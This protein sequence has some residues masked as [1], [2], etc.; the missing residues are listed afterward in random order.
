MADRIALTVLRLGKEEGTRFLPYDDATG[1]PIKAPVGKITW[2]RGFNLEAI[3]SAPLFDLIEGF[4]LNLIQ[5]QIGTFKWYAIADE[6]RKSVFLDIAYNDGVAGLLA[7]D[8]MLAAAAVED[9]DTAA[10]ECHVRNPELTERYEKLAE[11]LRT[12]DTL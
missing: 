11:L 7:F 2:G 10:K 8:K 4:L 9:W 6:T 3:G 12:G 5:N 1:K